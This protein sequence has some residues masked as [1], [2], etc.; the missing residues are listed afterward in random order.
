MKFSVDVN[1]HF[2][3]EILEAVKHWN[4]CHKP[5]I[6]FT[7][8]DL[9]FRVED[10]HPAVPFTITPIVAKDSEGHVISGTFNQAVTSDNP[11][12]VAVEVGTDGVS[13]SVT[14]GAPGVANITNQI[15]DGNGNAVPGGARVYAFEVTTGK[16]A[17]FEGGD[18][19]FEGLTDTP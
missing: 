16:P 6:H 10:D 9:M 8:G 15:T 3:E 7:G 11:D 5:T 19:T 2:P 12:V 13:G 17:V 14:F 4:R 1:I 18:V